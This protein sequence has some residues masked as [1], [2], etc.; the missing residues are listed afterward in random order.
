MTGNAWKRASLCY[1]LVQM[2]VPAYAL[3]F[4]AIFCV[5]LP[6]GCTGGQPKF[7]IYTSI[8]KEVIEE[9]KPALHAAYPDVRIEFYQGGSETIASKVNAQIAAGRTRADLILTSDPFWYL[10]LKKAGELL[11]YASPSARDIPAAFR[12]PEHTFTEVR[13]PVMVMAYHSGV[14]KEDEIPKNWKDLADPRWKKKLA[15]PSPLE[16]GT[17]FAAVA[18]LSK[19]Y[20]WD[21]FQALRANDIL[22]AGGNSSVITRIETKERPLGIVLLENVLKAQ[23]KKSPVRPIYPAD[24]TIP[25]TS[26]IAIL[27]DSRQPELAKKIYDWFFSADAQ[28]AMVKS[29]M[30]SRVEGITAPLN[31]RALPEL[32]RSMMPWSAQVLEELYGE[33]DS[34]KTKFT[35]IVLH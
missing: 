16:S 1:A 33:R 29:G 15:M 17:A 5:L 31:A 27:K 4:L 10:E 14:L 9:M 11:P 32:S 13:L 22:A 6:S 7:W 21:F 34:I 12:D 25:V 2:R 35:E 20:G 30:Y 24:G 3:R 8:Y 23:S 28:R 18:L 19:K 26:P